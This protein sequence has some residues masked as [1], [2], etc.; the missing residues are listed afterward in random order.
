[1]K[2]IKYIIGIAALFFAG[3]DAQMDLYDTAIPTVAI[4]G[5]WNTSLGVQD[6]FDGTAMLYKDGAV[7]KEYLSRANSVTAIVSRGQ[8]DILLFNGV[9]ESEQVTNLD[10]IFFRG[11]D[12]IATFE[13][14]AAE[15][16]PSRRLSRLDDE[17]IANNDMEIFT[18]A[19]DG[20]FIES[21]LQDYLKYKNGRKVASVPENYVESEVSL[22]PRAMSYRFQVKIANL[23]NPSSARAA[24]GAL[25]GFTGSVFP[26]SSQNMPES[27]I[28]ATHH[29]SLAAASGVSIWTDDDG[30]ELGKIQSPVFV[31]F[32]P[33]LPASTGQLPASGKYTFD[34]VFVLAD[35][36]EFKL[37]QPIDVTPQVNAAIERIFRHHSGGGDIAIGEN[38]FVIE[39]TDRIEL[40]IIMPDKIV[41]VIDWEDE[42]EIIV[43]I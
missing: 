4:E 24:S 14:V 12:R 23:V 40:P 20:V 17:Y 39:I 35:N 41:D 42:E 11:T 38:L 32:G 6:M 22:V 25:L 28:P 8:Y 30:T 27:G 29:L 10:H 19:R 34:P 16:T 1:M 9:M 33:P 5:N 31:S 15:G 43:W 26:A 7:T 2:H 21:E 36:T 13:A 37:P 3:C 18:F